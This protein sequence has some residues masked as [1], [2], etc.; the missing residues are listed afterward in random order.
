MWPTRSWT[1]WSHRPSIHWLL[2]RSMMWDL[3]SQWW[4]T[5]LLVG[6]E[7]FADHADT[8]E[9]SDRDHTG[10]PFPCSVDVVPVPKNLQFSDV[11]Q[12]SF[13]ATWEHGSPDMAMY[14]IGWSKAGENDFQYVSKNHL[15]RN[16]LMVPTEPALAQLSGQRRQREHGKCRLL[17]HLQGHNSCILLLQQFYPLALCVGVFFIRTS[18]A[19]TRQAMSWRT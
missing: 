5:R 6:M 16:Y 7:A 17:N 11:T 18:W 3:A 4:E 15:C 10:L 2:L 14:R 8:M 19:M 1:I 12:T 9:Y 13:R